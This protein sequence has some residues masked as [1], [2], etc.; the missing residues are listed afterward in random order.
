MKVLTKFIPILAFLFS[1]SAIACGE[2]P[3]MSTTKDDGAKVGIFLSSS[4]VEQT[5]HWQ[6][7]EGE[8]PLSISDAY[9]L[10]KEWAEHE[11]SRYDT[12]RIDSI[13][14]REYGCSTV[15]NRWYYLL[16]IR[17]VIDGNELFGS[18][19]WAAVLFDRT[20]IGPREY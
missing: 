3:V 15:R 19:D 6:P 17:P 13:T 2:H 12:V 14:L 7:D 20:V 5:T 8:P 11:Y 4:A 9:R 10:V 16:D 1:S 18:G